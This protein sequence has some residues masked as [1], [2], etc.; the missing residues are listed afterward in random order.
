MLPLIGSIITISIG[1]IIVYSDK[2]SSL[3]KI[4]FLISACITIWL[5]GTFMMF[6]NRDNIEAVIF[7]DK[8]IYAGVVFVPALLYHFGLEIMKKR[9]DVILYINYIISFIFLALSRTSYFMDGVYYY[10]WGVHTQAKIMH[11]VFL[12]WFFMIVIVW[13]YRTFI[14]YRSLKSELLRQ[15]LNYVILASAIVLIVGPI[16]FVPAYGIEIYPFSHMSA[17]LFISILAYS[18]IK[19]RFMSVK[20]VLKDSIVFIVSMITIGAIVFT[21]KYIIDYYF[22]KLFFWNDFLIILFAIALFPYLKR[23]FT[24]LANKYFFSSL[25]NPREITRK[26]NKKILSTLNL[27]ELVNHVF[28]SLDLAFHPKN[29]GLLKTAKKNNFTFL[30]TKNFSI[31]SEN[32]ITFSKNTLTKYLKTNKPIISEE[33]KNFAKN[34]D[35]ELIKFFDKFKIELLMP[36][37][38]KN[39]LIGVISLGVKS[40]NELYSNVDLELIELVAGIVTSALEN[41]SLYEDLIEK[42]K[43]LNELLEMKS[44]FLK[45]VHNQLNSPL[46][47]I[48]YSLDAGEKNE[49][50]FN[51]SLVIARKGL[52]RMN[53]TLSDFW[54]AYDVE[55]DKLKMNIDV[56][57]IETLINEVIDDKSKIQSKKEGVKIIINKSNFVLAPVLCDQDQIYHAITNLINNSIYYTHKRTVT[58]SYKKITKNN[59]NY[60]KILLSD[61]GVGIDEEDKKRLFKKFSRGSK[62]SL[63]RTNG[64]GLGLY[65]SKKI[66]EANGGELKLENSIINK[67]SVFSF[68]LPLLN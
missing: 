5:F 8:F 39:K 19:H 6:L 44:D 2:K 67:G 21:L 42:N 27:N 43:N 63:L 46:S 7:W 10:R 64:S 68:T 23:Y 56:V 61:T 24:T 66:I 17:V 29:I 3:N 14:Y 12:I 25:Y 18:I 52:E 55:G 20:F 54:I 22:I 1:F 57:D 38:I 16:A 30:Y 33:Y 37:T 26:L 9:R 32:I 47:L 34:P 50:P 51:E 59:K 58:V 15:Q 40:S 13:A 41:A 11:T 65:V 49:I 62:A 45:V 36:L 48:Q 28:T 35:K 60:L 4:F 53:N 31:S